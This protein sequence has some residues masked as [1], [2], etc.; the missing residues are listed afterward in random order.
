MYKLLIADDEPKIRRGL[1]KMDWN[2]I[3]VQVVGEAENGKAARQLAQEKEP[4]IMFVDI[5]MPFLSG[6]ELIRELKAILPH[7]MMIIISGYDEFDYAKK[8]VHLGVFDY[9]LKPVNKKELIETVTDAI[10]VLETNQK[11][12]AYIN[13]A[14]YQVKKNKHTIRQQLLSDWIHGRID[15]QKIYSQLNVLNVD[16]HRIRLLLMIKPL[17]IQNEH[18]V[19]ME[20]DLLN[21]CIENMLQ[22]IL[23]TYTQALTFHTNTNVVVALLPDVQQDDLLQVEHRLKKMVSQYLGRELLMDYEEIGEDFYELPMYYQQLYE[24]LMT[25]SQHTPIVLLATCYI[26]KK[27]YHQALSLVEVSKALNVSP[28]YLSRLIKKELGM[29]FKE[30]LT[31]V[32]ITKAMDFM[33]NPTIKLYEIAENVGYSTQHYFS[34]AF[35]KVTGESPTAF[36]QRKDERM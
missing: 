22:E 28:A 34:S 17:D 16:Y 25:H 36:R 12:N 14:K 31:K 11:N 10:K 30:Y 19:K 26:E 35:K 5:C 13:W 24:R 4:D 2:A 3:G 29:T 18:T 6:I 23:G 21:F 20:H 32:R 33:L 27:Y 1:S 9:V 7:C 8:A 15:N